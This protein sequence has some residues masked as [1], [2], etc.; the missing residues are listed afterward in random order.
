MTTD[1]V[2]QFLE[3][4]SLK[5]SGIWKLKSKAYDVK[6]DGTRFLIRKR[7]GGA[8]GAIQPLIK[9]Q[10]VQTDFVQLNLDIKPSYHIILFSFL[11]GFISLFFILSDDKM[12]INNEFRAPTL[13]ERIGMALFVL[14]IPAV[15]SYFKTIQPVQNAEKWLIR[16]LKLEPIF[17]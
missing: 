16:R 2:Y 7:G 5:E 9:G 13:L 4:I 14:L 8:N 11:A 6:V 15:I 12:T 3:Y 17:N 10:V 1:Q